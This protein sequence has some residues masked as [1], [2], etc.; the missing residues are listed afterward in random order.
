MLALV[1]PKEKNP[2]AVELGKLRAANMTAGERRDLARSGGVVGGKARAGALSKRRRIEIAKAA[3]AA[4][5][6]KQKRD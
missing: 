1:S 6:A 3:A 5:W 4:R 2:A